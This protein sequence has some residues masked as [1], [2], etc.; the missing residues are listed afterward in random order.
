MEISKKLQSKI[1]FRISKPTLQIFPNSISL[2]VDRKFSESNSEL[3]SEIPQNE[4][5][6]S[7]VFQFVQTIG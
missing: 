5:C 7:I 2:D 4:D 6:N 3:N 1:E